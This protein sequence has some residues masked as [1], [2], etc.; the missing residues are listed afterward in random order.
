MVAGM[1]KLALRREKNRGA[2]ETM[3]SRTIWIECTNSVILDIYIRIVYTCIALY[4]RD[5]FI[6][7]F[8]CYYLQLKM[9]QKR[10]GCSPRAAVARDRSISISRLLAGSSFRRTYVIVHAKEKRSN[11]R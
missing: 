6:S 8:S 10:C 11:T 2:Q 3:A 4:I 5:C 1:K 9:Q 7:S